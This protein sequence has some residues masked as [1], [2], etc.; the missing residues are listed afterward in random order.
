VRDVSS[1][2]GQIVTR[3]GREVLRRSYGGSNSTKFR[4]LS[5]VARLALCETAKK[6]E[7]GFRLELILITNCSAKKSARPDVRSAE[8]T[9]ASIDKLART[10]VGRIRVAQKKVLARDLYTGP[11][12]VVARDTA[13]RHGASWYV[14]SAGLGLVHSS[15]RVPAY[16][17]TISRKGRSSVL[18]KIEGEAS[19][20]PDLWWDALTR[21]QGRRYP[22]KQ[23]IRRRRNALV[24]IAL[25][26]LYLD[27]VRGDLLRLAAKDIR[28]IRI[29]SSE[30]TSLPDILRPALMPYDG[31]L[32]G[33]GS[34]EPGPMA[35]FA[36]RAARHFLKR[37]LRSNRKSSLRSD[38]RSVRLAFN[39]IERP[40]HK[41]RERATDQ[42]IRR[43]SV[44]LRAAGAASPSAALRQLRR[45]LR[46]ACE[47]SRF[48]RIWNNEPSA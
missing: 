1:Q 3:G 39:G 4:R 26:G 10:W 12:A 25:S 47:Q 16:D 32:N 11:S 13:A 46:I 20:R 29:L 28:R 21:A 24:V 37:V 31:R 41:P 34:S 9:P 36:Q 42:E 44:K 45:N 18:N 27:M 22:I 19:K 23:L 30:T 2:N 33:K 14:A 48:L 5:V 17:V 7:R 6:A 8:L 43:L 15:R 35:S 40:Q 38:A